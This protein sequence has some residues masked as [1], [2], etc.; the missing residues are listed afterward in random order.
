[1]TTVC[2]G[3]YWPSHKIS[4]NN[5][6]ELIFDFLIMLGK[7]LTEVDVSTVLTVLQCKLSLFSFYH[8]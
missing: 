8:N 6:S 1:M 5:L 4:F 3:V 2:F 7:R